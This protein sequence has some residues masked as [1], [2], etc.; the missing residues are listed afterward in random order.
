MLREERSE[1]LHRA[2]ALRSDN[3]RQAGHIRHIQG[4]RGHQNTAGT[5]RVLLKPES[6]AQLTAQLATLTLKSQKLFLS[7]LESSERWLC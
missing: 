1:L 6:S 2:S 7:K 5:G 4:T 3:D